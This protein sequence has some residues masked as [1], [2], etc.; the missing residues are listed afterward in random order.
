MDS[1]S[2]PAASA[3]HSPPE[4][5]SSPGPERADWRARLSQP[6]VILTAAML[7]STVLK[8]W[9]ASTTYGSNDVR[10]WQ[11]F[12]DYVV[13]HGWVTIY[14]D[15]WYYNHPPLM[16]LFL[17]AVKPLTPIVPHGFPLIMR[18]PAITADA[19]CGFVVYRLISACWNPR[20][21]LKAAV[22]FWCSPVLLLVSGFHGNTDPVFMCLVLLG[23]ERLVLG[24]SP[25]VAGLLVGLAM[26]IKIVP[27]LA[28]PAFFFSLT[29][30]KDRARLVGAFTLMVVLG[31]GYHMIV[32]RQALMTNVFGYAS[33]S[34][35]LGLTWFW[36]IAG[37]GEVNAVFAPWLK[38]LMFA[39][40]VLN[41]FLLT[42]PI[43]QKRASFP[44]S[45]RLMLE[46]LGW[47][48]LLFLVFSPVFGVQY[49]AWF[50]AV[51]LFLGLTGAA[52]YSLTAG[53]FIFRVY[54]FWNGG[55]F[56][57]QIADSDKVGPWHGVESVVG[58]YF[59]LFVF[60]WFVVLVHRR[61]IRWR[62]GSW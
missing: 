31:F 12:Q 10:Y 28:M 1:A 40:I 11:T 26:N 51:S 58:M 35:N 30:W 38:R 29:T 56:P 61:V 60:A 21:A 47:T 32:A 55:V 46:A 45:G 18:I 33:Q 27:I 43:R 22:I 34:G 49:T 62:F 13:T 44:A 37:A 53:Y 3:V 52:L 2:S 4:A 8:L 16:S 54:H 17:W 19:I 7:I 48:F 14:R 36:N 15:I 25:L 23:A 20:R 39:L 6:V 50:V 57:W 5:T 24:R 42:R 41:S 59:W 9:L